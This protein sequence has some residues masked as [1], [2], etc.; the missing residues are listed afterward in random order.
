MIRLCPT[1]NREIFPII[2][3]N[4]PFRTKPQNELVWCYRQAFAVVEYVPSIYS[5]LLHFVIDKCLEMDVEIKIQ[6]T[7]EVAIEDE[8]E[9]DQGADH[10][11]EGMFDMELDE[12]KEKKKLEKLDSLVVNEMADKVC[13]GVPFC[14]LLSETKLIIVIH[15]FFFQLDAVMLL[16]FQFFEKEARHN[17]FESRKLYE[18]CYPAF[19]SSILIAYRSKFVQ[20]ILFFL[21]GLEN[22]ALFFQNL[23]GKLTQ[24]HATLY[25]EFVAKL[26]DLV[27]DP[28]RPSNVKQCAACYLASFISRARYVEAGTIC[29]CLCALL[30]WAD[31]YVAALPSF[32][33][34][35]SDARNQ[36]EL[37]PLFYTICQAAFY[38]MCFRGAEAVQF[39]REVEQRELKGPSDQMAPLVGCSLYDVD[40]QQVDISSARWIKICGHQLRPLRFCLETVRSEFLFI[41]RDLGLLDAKMIQ[42]LSN[43]SNGGSMWQRKKKTSLI[44]TPA[45][46]EVARHNGGVGG[47]GRGSNPLDSFFP[48]DPYLLRRSHEYIE[49]FYK[50]WGDEVALDNDSVEYVQR[51]DEEVDEEEDEDAKSQSSD[52]SEV[53]DSLNSNDEN[54]FRESYEDPAMILSTPTK[55]VGVL[56]APREAWT[57]TLKRSRAPSIESSGAGSW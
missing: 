17:V 40:L 14:W 38:V 24:Q 50:Q 18:R 53:D 39:Y 7:G 22:E 44:A 6:D 37:H 1:A 55:S 29:E 15:L 54:D 49:P 48:F 23:D 32:S 34:S 45:T 57:E 8:G 27:M 3:I 12:G 11:E 28:Y 43:E 35:A 10:S 2:T 9:A 19:E 20:F 13:A 31:T 16:T 30:R 26:L 33:I 21:C 41:A 52:L 25:R 47:L 42:R 51:E 4:F 46:L 56:S 5:Q 36:T